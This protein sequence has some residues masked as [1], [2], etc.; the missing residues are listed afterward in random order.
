MTGP[1]S[2]LD[3]IY[4]NAVATRKQRRDLRIQPPLIRIW[5]GDWNLRGI[6][7]AEYSADFKWLLNE[8]GTGLL[9]LPADH[10]LAEWVMDARHR[11]T[12][13]VHVTVDKDGA[14]WSG[15]MK[16]ATLRKTESGL[17]SVAIQFMHDY[18]ELKF[19]QAWSN[20]FLPAAIQF[21]RVFM[22]AGP[23]RWCLKLALFLNILRKEASLWALPDDPLDP[24]QWFNLDQSKWSMVVAPN[25]FL[26]DT[27]VW[28]VISSRWKTWH[29]MAAPTLDDAQLMVTCRRYLDGDPPPWPGA[30]L[31][32]GCLVFDIV[33]KSGFYTGSGTSEGGSLLTGL[34][35]TIQ[36]FTKDFLEQE[37]TE[38]DPNSPPEYQKPDWLG[39]LPSSPWVIYRE[40]EYTGIQTSEFT[41]SPA[42]AVQI[43]TGGHSAY[44]V[45]EG[46]SAA[47]NLA[48]DLMANAILGVTG[49]PLG[50]TIDAFLKPLYRD[51]ILAWLSFKSPLRAPRMGWSHYF[52]HFQKG[53]ESGY[54]L[55]GLV[56]LRAGLWATRAFTSHKLT[57]ADGAPYLIGENGQGHFFLGDRVG[58]TVAGMPPGQI[59][60]DQVT[61][62]ELSWRRGVTPGWA[63]TIGDDKALEDPV[64]RSLRHIQSIMGDLHELGVM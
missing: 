49:V 39:T 55:S 12:Q 11:T 60:V 48:G 51:T 64:T 1:S 50:G 45:N 36:N 24:A 7:R 41:I 14:R 37:P 9:E 61:A 3:V 62:L 22:L 33:D 43:N 21:P 26:S 52:E 31:R 10:Y 30:N 56:A 57:V 23:S 46:I 63:V 16:S 8:S 40:S 54:S 6:C 25:D 32:H 29:D 27:S 58:A 53:A 20:P 38:V 4:R 59:F 47:V 19:I 18:H 44:G 13:N 17:H 34:I 5:D 28:T 15:R 35:H 42:T 2:D